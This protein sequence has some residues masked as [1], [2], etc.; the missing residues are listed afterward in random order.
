MRVAIAAGSSSLRKPETKK[1]ADRQK[2]PRTASAAFKCEVIR[3]EG[4]QTAFTISGSIPA[5][6]S[7]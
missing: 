1:I 7:R 6:P 3:R 5:K 2:R 4:G